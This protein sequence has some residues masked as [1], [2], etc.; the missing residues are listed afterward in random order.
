V[1]GSG[2][3]SLM[4]SFHMRAEPVD[5]QRCAPFDKLRAH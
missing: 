2:V 4:G 3:I 1:I 5:A